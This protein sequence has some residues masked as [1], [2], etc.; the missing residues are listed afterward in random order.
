L[1]KASITLGGKARNLR[2]EMNA[3]PELEGALRLTIAEIGRRLQK[4]KVGTREVRA[5]VWAGLLHEDEDLTIRQV[6]TWLTEAD[7]LKNSETRD[8]IMER[9]FEA[10]AESFP[11]AVKDAEATDPN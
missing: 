3:L 5:L 4:G 6:G 7:F 9:V 10:L 2:Y 11:E 1:A 8:K